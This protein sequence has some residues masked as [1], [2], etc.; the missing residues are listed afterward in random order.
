MTAYN[1][2]HYEIL[3]TEK[4]GVNS[5]RFENFLLN[6]YQIMPPNGIILMDNAKIYK[7]PKIIG[8]LTY[9]NINHIFLSPYSPDYNPIELLFSFMKQEMKNHPDLSDIESIE[10]SLNKVTDAHLKSWIYFCYENW[11]SDKL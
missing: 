2:I 1:I 9:F 10:V 6:L 4:C 8:I 3:S 11:I 5:E 7:T